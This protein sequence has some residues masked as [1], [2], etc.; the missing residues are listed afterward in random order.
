MASTNSR[1][2]ILPKTHAPVSIISPNKSNS[3]SNT[4]QVI[5]CAS[6]SSSFRTI[7]PRL[8]QNSS[9][10]NSEVT[11]PNDF[12]EK[13]VVHYGDIESGNQDLNMFR[14]HRVLYANSVVPRNH[15]RVTHRRVLLPSHTIPRTPI[16]ADTLPSGP[17][18]SGFDVNEKGNLRPTVQFL[19]RIG[20][21]LVRSQ[22]ESAVADE[23]NS[24]Q[25][26]LCNRRKRR[27]IEEK[28]T[29]PTANKSTV[30]SV[31]IS[32]LEWKPKAR[33]SR[34]EKIWNYCHDNKCPYVPTSALQLL[35][36]LEQGH[37]KLVNIDPVNAPR[38]TR[39]ERL[40]SCDSALSSTLLYGD[41]LMGQF[42]VPL[43]VNVSEHL[44]STST[45]TCPVCGQGH[46]TQHTLE[47][48]LRRNHV[49]LTLQLIEKPKVMICSVC[50]LPTQSTLI[51]NS[52]YHAHSGVSLHLACK[53]NES[54]HNNAPWSGCDAHPLACLMLYPTLYSRF[55]L[56]F[57]VAR[58]LYTLTQHM[59]MAR[60][61][62]FGG[63]SVQSYTLRCC[64]GVSAI[65]G[66]LVDPN[67]VKPFI[68]SKM[69]RIL[70]DKNCVQALV[71]DISVIPNSSLCTSNPL[72]TNQL[73]SRSVLPVLVSSSLLTQPNFALPSSVNPTNLSSVC[74]VP[75]PPV[76]QVANLASRP[77]TCSTLPPT[78]L[79]SQPTPT[80]GQKRPLTFEPTFPVCVT[81][82]KQPNVSVHGNTQIP[83]APWPTISSNATVVSFLPS[84]S[85]VSIQPKPPMPIPLELS[86]DELSQQS[87]LS[88]GDANTVRIQLGPNGQ[89]KRSIGN[90]PRS[91]PRVLPMSEIPCELCTT[92][93]PTETNAQRFHI[94]CHHKAKGLARIPTFPCNLC[95]QLFWTNAGLGWHQK[96]SCTFCKETKLCS[97]TF[98]L[99][100]IIKHPQQFA[101]LLTQGVYNCPRCCRIFPDM[102]SFI[103]HIQVMH[104]F[105]V[106]DD[107]NALCRY[108]LSHG[109]TDC[110]NVTIGP[111]ISNLL[112]LY[113]SLS[114]STSVAYTLPEN[115]AVYCKSNGKTYMKCS[116]CSSHFLTTSHL[117]LHMAQASHQYWCRLCPY[118]CERAISLWKHY[119]GNHKGN[120]KQADQLR[121]ANY[122]GLLSPIRLSPPNLHQSRQLQH[123]H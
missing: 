117:D 43:T 73:D 70:E 36:H 90:Q 83:A 55:G 77:V 112:T 94:F 1:R 79:L 18:Q 68:H 53:H 48:H 37:Q 6:S 123:L 75:T 20:S 118:A 3:E 100:E 80:I 11:E 31:N 98:Y 96:G 28:Q 60:V 95:G 5:K 19:L 38:R 42:H 17:C 45:Y 101:H 109:Q 99:H 49:E 40:E 67:T 30:D 84:Q 103:I 9:V 76:N 44:S 107:L 88:N 29:H 81:V 47:N 63:W 85:K 102:T 15:L 71:P 23:V 61:N 89:I 27:R 50:G 64:A 54:I 120:R 21:A 22:Y 104:F 86:S 78:I 82:T 58:F 57:K 97:S 12:N 87:S 32:H 41:E 69:S 26:L 8:S 105:T 4:K 25:S 51:R 56:P 52:S 119:C 122:I 121:Q 113:S 91:L 39:P 74:V 106:P 7:A 65:F 10:V 46:K 115:V 33:H 108:D 14:N 110:D 24:A 93:I 92:N 35:R 114:L 16:N 62:Q 72:E 13:D 116:V 34:W 2:L 59:L 111:K 66:E